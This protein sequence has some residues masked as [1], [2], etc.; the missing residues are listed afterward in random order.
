MIH[1]FLS[2]PIYMGAI[3]ALLS[4]DPCPHPELAEGGP[5]VIASFELLLMLPKR[6]DLSSDYSLAPV[7][8]AAGRFATPFA[9][10]ALEAWPG[11]LNPLSSY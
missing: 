9:D 11:L 6:K 2:V 1:S 7:S 10:L 4:D 8:N 5:K 3:I